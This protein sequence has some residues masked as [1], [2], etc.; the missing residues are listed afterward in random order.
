MS[1]VSKNAALEGI[2]NQFLSN[3]LL[4]QGNLVW[5]LQNAWLSVALAKEQEEE[6]NTKLKYVGVSKATGN[7]IFNMPLISVANL[8]YAGARFVLLNITST[9]CAVSK[10]ALSLT[11]KVINCY[12]IDYKITLMCTRTMNK[13][14]YIYHMHVDSQGNQ[15]D[16][17]IARQ[18]TPIS[19]I[20][21]LTPVQPKK[22]R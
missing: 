5:L 4:K 3:P 15:L 2:Q 20:F 13:Y 12:K 9:I 6:Q 19:E 7:H 18:S 22:R 17:I 10:P 11:P 1:Y 14:V 16:N 21:S 8:F